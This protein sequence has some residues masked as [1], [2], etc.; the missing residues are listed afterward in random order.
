MSPQQGRPS[1]FKFQLTVP[2]MLAEVQTSK[3]TI[4]PINF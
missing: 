1:D 3:A 2:T 4:A